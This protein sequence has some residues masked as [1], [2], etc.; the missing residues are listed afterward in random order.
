MH[1]QL[2]VPKHAHQQEQLE[3][4]GSDTVNAVVNDLGGL[5]QL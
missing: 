4:L 2:A 3:G 1:N 5:G